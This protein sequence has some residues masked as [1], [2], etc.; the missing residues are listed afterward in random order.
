MAY[1]SWRCG[2][3][4]A[5]LLAVALYFA[6]QE[7]PA[8][9]N[10][11]RTLNCTPQRAFEFLKDPTNYKKIHPFV[12]DV[13]IVEFRKQEDGVEFKTILV[14][15]KVPLPFGYTR[16]LVY[17]IDMISYDKNM[18]IVAPS[19]YPNFLMHGYWSFVVLPGADENTAEV[20]DS[21]RL[22]TFQVTRSYVEAKMNY[23]HTEQ[24]NA[25]QNALE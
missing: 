12:S 11:R 10:A 25:L 13:Q 20:V 1:C 8:D 21:I 4:S 3:A 9:F 2:A 16:T 14:T 15:D 17:H 5:V 7:T 18:T 6:A 24:L 23:S 19:I 22:Y